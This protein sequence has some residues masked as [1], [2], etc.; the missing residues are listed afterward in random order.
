[1]CRR[2]DNWAPNRG[3][4]RSYGFKMQWKHFVHSGF[5]ILLLPLFLC[6]T[7]NLPTDAAHTIPSLILQL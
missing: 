3:K 6:Y 5:I 1:M 2:T 7:R 4:S